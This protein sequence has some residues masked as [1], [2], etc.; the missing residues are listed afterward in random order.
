MDTLL[1][2]IFEGSPSDARVVTN[3]VGGVIGW[4][5]GQV[6]PQS[7]G[8]V[9]ELLWLG[10]ALHAHRSGVGSAL[11]ADA[12]A[13]ARAGGAR[14]FLVS[15]SSNP[16]TQAA[17]ALYFNAGLR[18]CGVVK[19]GYGE[20]D[21]VSYSA[22]L[23]TPL[24]LLPARERGAARRIW[25]YSLQ[26]AAPHVPGAVY[27]LIL[28]CCSNDERVAEAAVALWKAGVAP[29]VLFSGG[30][31]VLTAGRWGGLPEADAFAAVAASAGLPREAT[32]VETKSRNTGENA[33]FS[34]A[35]FPTPPA[36]I[37]LVTKPFMER[38]ALAT[39]LAQWPKDTGGRLPRFAV[40]SPQIGLDDYPNEEM[41]LGLP[42]VL[43]V[44]AGDLQ[45]VIVYPSL[46]HQV[47]QEV[48]TE[49]RVALHR[50][51]VAGHTSHLLRVEGGVAGSNDPR[52]YVGLGE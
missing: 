47:A 42:A 31:G 3:D 37:C 48:P 44:A 24:G 28:V 16:A 9:W 7:E 40:T 17:R 32:L 35:L 23:R 43:A 46:G 20:D 11:L 1:A 45:R 10:V 36:S 27:D 2:P 4:A 8:A 29:R 49:V 26:H 50:L 41:G 52:M 39:F 33:K 12:E 19:H 15:T 6:D 5:Y 51:V 22:L 21:K 13:I 30:E 38:R 14:T 34:A 18:V 25:E